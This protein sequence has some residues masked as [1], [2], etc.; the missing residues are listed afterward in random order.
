MPPEIDVRAIRRAMGL[1]RRAFADRFGFALGTVRNWEQ[2][3][4]RPEGPARVLLLV[5]QHQ[6]DAVRRALEAAAIGP[7]NGPIGAAAP[8][9][10]P[11]PIPAAA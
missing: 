8:S 10:A 1:S 4:R 3:I 5:I 11:P 9:G 6:P 7:W 2:G